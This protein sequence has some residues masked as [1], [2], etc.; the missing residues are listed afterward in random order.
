MADFTGK[1]I[2]DTYKRLIQ[3]SGAGQQ[4]LSASAGTGRYI[5]DGAGNNSPVALSQSRMGIN[6][7]SPADLLHIYDASSSVGLRIDSILPYINLIDNNA[8]V[9]GAGNFRISTDATE[10]SNVGA[11]IVEDVNASLVSQ[12]KPFIIQTGAD[13]NSLYIQADNKIGVGTAAPLSLFHVEST[14]SEKFRLSYDSGDY[15]KMGVDSNGATT[16]TTVDSDGAAGHLALMPDGYVGIGTA[17]PGYTLDIE[18][19]APTLNLK[20]TGDT[21][22]VAIQFLPDAGESNNDQAR[23]YIADAGVWGFQTHST[24]SW[25]S[26]MTILNTGNVGI[27]TTSPVD[28]LDISSSGTTSDYTAMSFASGQLRIINST[29]PAD[30]TKR[31]AAITFAQRDDEVARIVSRMNNHD[32]A[33]QTYGDLRFLTKGDGESALTERMTILDTG[34]VGIGTTDPGAVGSH[35]NCLTVKTTGGSTRGAMQ[36]DGNDATNAHAIL[37][38]MSDGVVKSYIESRGSSGHLNLIPDGYVG[39]GTITPDGNLHVCS[40]DLTHVTPYADA[41]EFVIGGSASANAG[42]S[43]LTPDAQDANIV[44]GSPTDAIGA[45]IV[46]NHDGANFHIRTAKVGHS[47]ILGGDNQIPVC[48]MS[49]ASGSEITSFVGKVGIGTAAPDTLLHLES[50]DGTSRL[51]FTDTRTSMTTGEIG[52]LEFETKDSG[53]AGVGAYILG[54]AGGTGGEVDLTFATGL[55]ASGGA[56]RMRITSEGNVGIGISSASTTLHV[57]REDA[58]GYTAANSIRAEEAHILLHNSNSHSSANGGMCGIGFDTNTANMFFGAV[59]NSATHDGDFVFVTDTDY[60]GGGE[61]M[62]I[63]AD[64]KVGIGTTSPDTKLE[65]VGSFAANG[66]SSTFVTF[67]DG[68]ATPSVATGNIFKHHASTQTINMFDDG[69]CGQIITVIST[70]AITY[71]FNASNLKCGS[72][73]IVTANGDVTMWVFDGTNWYLISWMDVDANLADGSAGGF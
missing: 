60:A 42:M 5:S 52:K 57:K 43:I 47:L 29:D 4:E 2:Q 67:S 50:N 32:T 71:D 28:L 70:A 15:M 10:D 9:S 12:G 62:R 3:L 33:A 21:N 72:A 23:L 63:L 59:S 14:T 34:Y 55:G 1:K 40:Q 35:S 36:I 30:D 51:R 58:S 65:V 49:G 48:T 7:T 46:Y 73:D 22:A 17:T 37:E 8:A 20:A 41:D 68:D 24:G 25:V 53:S 13:T 45:R 61:A 54:V 31:Y 26:S 39:I 56:E 44:F 16:I 19:S 27:G 69:I 6:T 66:P 18:A 11:F 38:F 64:G